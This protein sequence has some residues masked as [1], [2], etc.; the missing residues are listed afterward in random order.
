MRLLAAAC[1][2]IAVSASPARAADDDAPKGDLAKVQGK[3]KGKL[4][5]GADQ[6]VI[7]LVMEIKNKNV[8]INVTPPD[9][10]AIE[11]KGEIKL[12]EK[13]KPK[14]WDWTKFTGP[15]GD[16]PGDNLAIYE[17]DGDSLKICSGGPNNPRPTEMKA[18]DDGPP[19]L[20]TFTRSKEKDDAK[21]K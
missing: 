16:A 1:L 3:W 7:Q 9:G 17:L 11:I 6:T 19:N 5:V 12:D 2:V 20:V 13:A 15:G 21:S 18:G 8:T 10:E 14:A 4:T